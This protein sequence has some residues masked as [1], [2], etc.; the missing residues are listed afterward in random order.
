MV[1]QLLRLK[2]RLLFNGFRIRRT[3][4]WAVVGI[5]FGAA[6]VVGV[7]FGMSMLDRLD[8][9]TAWRV[10]AIGGLVI[11]LAAFLGPLMVARSELLDPRALRALV[12]RRWTLVVTLVL[13]T[14]VGPAVVLVALAFAPTAYWTG[15]AREVAWGVAPLLVLEGLLAARLGVAIGSSLAHR[16]LLSVVTKVLAGAVLA[17]GVLLL[18]AQLVPWAAELLPG[19]MWRWSLP[20]VL[21]TAPL[22]D[23]AVFAAID[24]TP[25][26]AL[27]RAPIHEAVLPGDTVARDFQFGLLVIGVLVVLWIIRLARSQ[28]ATRRRPRE[29]AARVPG[30]F[31]RLPSTPLGAITSRTLTYWVRD[32]RYFTALFVLP[33]IPVV[34]LGAAMIGG[35]PFHW[36]VLVPLP[37]MV[38]LLSWATLHNDVAYDATAVWTHVAA[39]TPGPSD[40]F[41][42]AVPVLVLGAVLLAI[43][44][45]LTVWGYG[46]PAVAPPLLGVGIALLLGGVGVSSITSARSPYP[47]PRPGDRATQHP[48]VA[49]ESGAGVQ[50]GSLLG[51]ILVAAPALAA[52]GAWLVGIPGPWEWVAFGA[53]ILFGL[54]MLLLGIRLG[55][56]RFE[57]RGPELLAFA[58]RH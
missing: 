29:R 56:R 13:T 28:R 35:I 52:S 12:V 6:L 20:V 2:L 53:G 37:V 50:A 32:P 17:A 47:A 22:R 15:A 43:G 14:L 40:R 3:A 38:L 8:E 45:P 10:L 19:S 33:V 55:G 54:G 18:A 41:A 7:W 46:D 49:G 1:A 21:A 25:I 44:V 51:I 34:M 58:V 57:R 27:W 16:P 9:R 39:H 23:P 31:R 36:A 26:G 4:A 48:Q 24:A 11:S 5:L 42:R 30:W